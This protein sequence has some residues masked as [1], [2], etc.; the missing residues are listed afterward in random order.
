[1]KRTKGKTAAPPPPGAIQWRNKG[2]T[3]RMPGKIIKPNQTFW[4]KEH[5]VPQAFRDVIIPVNPIP[6]SSGVTVATAGYR[7]REKSA[8]LFDI[9]DGQGKILNEKALPKEEAQVILDKLIG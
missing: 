6:E 5:E 3:F 4:A 9:V 8:G 2:G 1:M 7:L